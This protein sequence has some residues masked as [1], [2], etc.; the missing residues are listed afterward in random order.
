L[1]FSRRAVNVFPHKANRFPRAGIHFPRAEYHFRRAGFYF[2][3][4]GFHFPRAEYHFS[5]AEYRFPRA[6]NRSPRTA[7]Q[8][9]YAAE[10]R[11][12]PKKRTAGAFG[13]VPA[14]VIRQG[15]RL[16]VIRH[17]S[18]V[19]QKTTTK[20]VAGTIHPGNTEIHFVSRGRRFN[21]YAPGMGFGA[22]I[23]NVAVTYR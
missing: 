8:A 17:G 23:L 7:N 14:A 9:R 6:K 18:W 20:P 11:R 22:I 12:M 4:A 15:N 21:R 3:R 13:L 2:S 19:R 5:R 16:S 10:G 1:G